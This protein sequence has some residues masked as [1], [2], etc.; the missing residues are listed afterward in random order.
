MFVKHFNTIG[1]ATVNRN[2]CLSFALLNVFS[3]SQEGF[4]YGT[5]K[6]LTPPL[7][8]TLCYVD[9]KEKGDRSPETLHRAMYL[10]FKDK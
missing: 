9:T 5:P 6:S 3:L 7:K 4:S 1:E 8:P 2:L 10:F